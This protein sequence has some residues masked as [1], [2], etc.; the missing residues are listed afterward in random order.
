[1]QQIMAKDLHSDELQFTI[2]YFEHSKYKGRISF[3]RDKTPDYIKSNKYLL[4]VAL[5]NI[6]DNACKYSDNLVSV[7]ACSTSSGFQIMV[8]DKGIGIPLDEKD[9]IFDTFYRTKNAHN[10]KG[11]GIG[12]SLAQKILKLSGADITVE[13]AENKGTTVSILWRIM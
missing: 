12:L 8:A 7:S 4:F 11:A 2:N 9:K 10:Y 5:Q 3:E 6:I 13:S 1:M